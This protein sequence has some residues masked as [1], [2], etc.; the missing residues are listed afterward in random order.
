[1]IQKEFEKH[2]DQLMEMMKQTLVKKGNDYSKEDRLSNFKEVGAISGT[3][4]ELACLTLIA[5]KVSRLGTLLRK[6]GIPNNES[7][8]DSAIDLANYAVILHAI[9]SEKK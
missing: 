6:G 8:E 2:V 5:T 3:S 9:I 1:M 7:I 4:A